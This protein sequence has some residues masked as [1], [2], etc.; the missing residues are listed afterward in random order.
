M[1]QSALFV[2][3]ALLC[4]SCFF[5]LRDRRIPNPLILAGALLALISAFMTAGLSGA[6]DAVTGF[7]VGLLLLT[8]PFAL[9]VIGAGDV[10]LLAMVGAFSGAA[11]LPSIL[12]WTCIAGGI[13]ALPFF[14]LR[15]TRLRLTQNMALLHVA[16]RTRAV[17]V[18]EL[19][20]K[21]A[22]RVPYALA[23]TLGVLI[24]VA[25]ERNWFRAVTL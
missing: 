6:L 1:S 22:A 16:L 25:L 3:T 14:F 18:S 23:I 21:S 2:M 10:K 15:R 24:H 4:T 5:D 7:A 11:A 13:V 20:L 19:G 17:A 9:R 8:L 12:M